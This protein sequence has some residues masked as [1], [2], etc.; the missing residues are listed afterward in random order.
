MTESE[1]RLATTAEGRKILARRY[2]SQRGFVRLR[3]AQRK[4][5][6]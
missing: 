3:E 2:E 4:T 1:K 6:K 5:A